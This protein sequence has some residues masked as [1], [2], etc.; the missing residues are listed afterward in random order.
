MRPS[1]RSL[2]FFVLL[3]TAP[4]LASCGPEEE[5]GVC[6]EETRAEPFELDVERAGDDGL[7]SFRFDDADPMPPDLNEN[8]WH[9]TVLDAG[10]SPVDGC[11]VLVEPWMP[12]HGHGSNEPTGSATGTSGQYLVEGLDLIMPGFW[13]VAG[14]AECDS[15]LDRSGYNLCIEG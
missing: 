15:V 6:A 8:D 5:D 12:D 4:L 10:G 1:P 11:S 13:A 3:A 2:F 7:L 9:I 14:S